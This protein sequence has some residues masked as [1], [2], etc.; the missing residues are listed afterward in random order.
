MPLVNHISKNMI[1]KSFCRAQLIDKD[2][3]LGI[4]VRWSLKKSKIENCTLVLS[5]SQVPINGQKVTFYE[6]IKR[7]VGMVLP[8][9]KSMPALG[10]KLGFGDPRLGFADAQSNP[11]SSPAHHSPANQGGYELTQ[12][13]T[14]PR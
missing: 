9:N 6:T 3:L 14:R 12:W 5:V 10:R 7:V 1:D 2:I 8:E 11:R 4:Q 13:R